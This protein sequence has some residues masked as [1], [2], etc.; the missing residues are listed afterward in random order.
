MRVLLADD[1]ELVAQTIAAY[2]RA[3]MRCDVSVAHSLG[4]AVEDVKANGTYDL[5]LLDL[6]MPGMNYLDGLEEMIS[7]NGGRPVAILSGTSSRMLAQE[8]ISRGA[9]GF[10]SKSMAPVSMISALRLMNMGET[11]YPFKTLVDDE[12]DSAAS[13]RTRRELQVLNGICAG[14]SN[15]EIARD[16]ELQEVTVKLHVK[17]LSRKLGARNR[18]HAAMI[19]RDRLLC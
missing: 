5:V 11:F 12:E 3:E 15:K 7:V 1:H 4:S 14:K 6:E 16:H 17:T 8:A 18:T 13:A 10:L 19:A 9:S 2:L